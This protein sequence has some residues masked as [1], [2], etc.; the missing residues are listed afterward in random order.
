MAGRAPGE[1]TTL[2][3]LNKIVAVD[4]LAARSVDEV[5]ALLH[6]ADQLLVEQA[7]RV[8]VQW[9]VYGHHV[10]APA[11]HQWSALMVVAEGNI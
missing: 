7:L 9:T 10:A 6:A 11:Q 1:V 3:G 4:D 2:Q 5:G 8:L